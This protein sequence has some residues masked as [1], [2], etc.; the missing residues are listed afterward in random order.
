MASGRVETF[1][2]VNSIHKKLGLSQAAQLRMVMRK[3]RS[4]APPSGTDF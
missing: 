1:V 2:F 4:V 3:I